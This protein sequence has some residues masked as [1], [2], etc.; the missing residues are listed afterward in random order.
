MGLKLKRHSNQSFPQ[1]VVSSHSPVFRLLVALGKK[2]IGKGG[3]TAI[4]WGDVINRRDGP[5]KHGR[6][7][8]G[9]SGTG[10]RL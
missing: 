9:G 7:P 10:G 2:F 1:F 5:Q 6:G 8:I 3:G 4:R